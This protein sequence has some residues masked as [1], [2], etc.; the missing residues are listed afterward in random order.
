MDWLK[1]FIRVRWS[2]SGTVKRAFAASASRRWLFGRNQTLGTEKRTSVTCP[3]LSNAALTGKHRSDCQD[4]VT[5]LE[6]GAND[7]QLG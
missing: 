7:Q 4:L 5:T 2:P 3:Q 6:L 1:T